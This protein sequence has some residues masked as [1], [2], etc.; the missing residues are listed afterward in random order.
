MGWISVELGALLLSQVP[1]FVLD[2]STWLSEEL[3]VHDVSSRKS[4]KHLNLI[5]R[6]ETE[7]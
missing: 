1:G 4:S 5:H 2:V 3:N 7:M 6:E